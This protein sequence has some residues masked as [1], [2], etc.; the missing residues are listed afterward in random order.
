MAVSAVAGLASA[1]GAAA[2]GL[3]FFTFEAL[4]VGAFFGYFALG[5]GLSALSRALAPTPKLGSQMRG[6]TQT[7]REPAGS[8]KLV[9]GQLRVGGQ[10][11]FIANSGTDNEYLHLVIVFAAHEIESFEEFWFNDNKV[12][13]NNAVVS[14]WSDYV[15]IAKFDGSQTTAD[16]TLTSVSNQWTNNHILNGM[17]YAHVRLKWDADQ[18]PQGVPNI[19]A[20]IKGKKVYD[21]RDSNQSATDASTWTYSQ[22]PALCVRDYLV[23]TKYGLGEDRTLIDSTALTA[24]A[25]LCEESISLD[26]GGTQDRYRL[27]G[28]I[29]TANQIKDNIEQMLSAMGGTMSYS[30]GK[31]F[32]RGAEY[33]TPTVTFDE[34][35]CVADIQLQ[36]KQSRRGAYNGVKGI[37][38]SEEK[39]YKVLDYPA[40][41]SSTYATE[42]GDPIYLDMPLPFVTNNVQAQRIAKIALLKSR[43]Q[44]VISMVVN[45]KGLRVKVGDTINVSN[46]HLGYSNK[47]FEVI[48]YSLAIADGGTLAVSLTCIE[49]ASAIY[50]WTTSDQEDFLSGGTLPLYDGRTVDNV[51]SLQHSVV[52]LKGPDGKLITSVDLT[53][54]A[55]N[56]AF[57]EFYVVT[58]EKDSDGDVYE[59]QTRNPRVRLSELTIGSA[60]TFTVK[61]QNLIGVRS[62]GTTL[63]VASL[64]GDTTAPAV[65]TSPS[66]TGGIRQITVEWTEATDEDLALTLIYYNDTDN[67]STATRS[68]TRGEE[69]VYT[70]ADGETSPKTKYFWLS[71]IDYSGNESA[72]TS[73]FTGTSVRTKENDIADGEVTTGKIENGAVTE[74]KIE[75]GAVTAGKI[76]VGEL[77]AITADIGDITAGTLQANT[78]TPIPDANDSPSGSET[79]AFIDLDNGKFVF[80]DANKHLLYDG[81][82]LVVKGE[83]EADILDVIDATI[84]GQLTANAI[85]AGAVT[86][87]SLSAGVFAEFDDRYGTS[88]GFYVTDTDEFFDGNSTKYVTVGTVAHSTDDIYFECRLNHSWSWPRNDTGDKL[89]AN[90]SFEY[91]TDNST[92]TTVPSSTTQV[93]T[94]TGVVAQYATLYS[95]AE[96]ITY[97]MTGSALT[98]GNYYFRVKIVAQNSTNAFQLAAFGSGSGVP[99]AFEVQESSGLS[100]AGGNADTLDGLDSTQFLRSDT[101]DTFDGNLTI[102]GDLILQG[103]IDQYNVTNLTVDDKTI[104]VNAGSTQALSDGA[105]LIVDRGTAADAS[106]TWDETN[107]E[108]DFSHDVTAPNLS[109]SNWNTAYTYSQVG[110]LP[111]A[112]GTVTGAVT[113]QDNVT[114]DSADINEIYIGKGNQNADQN[115][116]NIGASSSYLLLQRDADIPIELWGSKVESRSTHYF[117]S[118]A[119]GKYINTAG[120]AVLGDVTTA[121]IDSVGTAN[122]GN[123]GSG[124]YKLNIHTTGNQD[125][126]AIYATSTSGTSDQS[127]IRFFNDGGLSAHIGLAVD[128]GRLLPNTAANDFAIK[129]FGSL[130]LGNGNGTNL[131]TFTNTGNMK[132]GNDTVLTSNKALTNIASIDMPTS[133]SQIMVNAYSTT[134]QE[135]G[136][137]FFRDGFDSSAKYNLSIMARSRADDGSTDGLSINGYEGIAFSTGSNS[138]NERLFIDSSGNFDFNDGAISNAGAITSEGA[139]TA[140]DGSTSLG[141]YVGANQVINGSRVATFAQVISS[142]TLSG[143]SLYFNNSHSKTKIRLLGSTD[144]AHN[145]GTESYNN[146]YGPNSW[147]G[148]TIGHRFYGTPTSLIARL[149]TGGASGDLNSEFYGS[150]KIDQTSSSLIDH[151]VLEND[152]AGGAGGAIAFKQLGGTKAKLKSY[153]GSNQWTFAIDTEDTTNAFEIY[154]DG[155]VNISGALESGGTTILSST[156]RF[157]ASNGTSVKA[158]YSFDGDSGTGISRTAAGRID[159]LSSGAIKAYIKTGTSNPISPTMYVDGRTEINGVVTWTGGSSTNANTAYGWGDHSTQGYLTSSSSIAATQLTGTINNNRLSSDVLITDGGTYSTGFAADLDTI[160]GF[161][162]HR[163]TGFTGTDHRAFTGHHNLIQIPNTS[164]SGPYEVQLAFTTVSSGTPEFKFRSSGVTW[165]DWV[166]VFNDG[167]HPNADKWTTA[168]T[169]SLTGAITGSVSWDGS[170]N[171]SLATTVGDLGSITVTDLTVDGTTNASVRID[172]ASTSHH[173]NLLYYTNGSLSWRIWQ[174][175]AD[176]TLAIRNE[177]STTN[178]ITMTN[179]DTLFAN[180]VTANGSF[181]TST[182]STAVG[183][184][185]GSTQILEGSTR[186]LKNIGTINSGSVTSSGHV[187]ATNFFIGTVTSDLINIHTD[188]SNGQIATYRNN[189]GYF[190]HRT[191]A[192][193]NNDGTTV[194]LQQRV[195]ND[196]NYSS[197]GNFT[198]HDFHLRTNNTNR[199]SIGSAGNVSISNALSIVNGIDSNTGGAGANLFRANT[200]DGRVLRLRDRTDNGGN[201]IQFEQNNGSGIW[202]V[203]GRSSQFYVYKNSGTGAGLKWNI[204]SSGNHTFNGDMA[205]VNQVTLGTNLST[206]N[207]GRLRVEGTF[208]NTGAASHPRITFNDDNF[209]IGA[210]GWATTGNN[211][212]LYLWSYNGAG[213]KIRFAV[214]TD[215]GTDVTNAAWTTN[216]TIDNDGNFDLARGALEVGGNTVI[217][218]TRRFYAS[219]GTVAKAAFSFDGESSTGMYKYGTNQIGFT[220]GGSLMAYV[221]NVSGSAA[222]IVQGQINASG[223]NSGNWNTAYGW[224]DH[225]TAGYLQ[226]NDNITVGTISSGAITTS[227]NFLM[228]GGYSIYLGTTSRFSSDNNGGFGINYG[229]TGGTATASLSIYNNTTATIQLNRNGTISSGAITSS[230]ALT[231][232]TGVIMNNG[233]DKYWVRW[234]SAST[235]GLYYRQTPAQKLQFLFGGSERWG[236]DASGNMNAYNNITAGGSFVT[237]TSS[238]AL[239][240]YAG[241]TQVFEGST[242]N[243]KNIGT[244]S[245]GAITSSGHIKT[246]GGDFKIGGDSVIT[247]NRDVYARRLF[248]SDYADFSGILYLRNTINVLNATDNGWNTFAARSNGRFNLTIGSLS[249][250]STGQFENI[251][252]GIAPSTPAI[253][254]YHTD[255]FEA[256]E[257]ITNAGGSLIRYRDNTSTSIEIG[258]QGGVPVIRTGSQARLTVDGSDLKINS[259]ALKIANTSVITSGRFLE[260]V[261]LEAGAAGARFKHS[262]WHQSTDGRNRFYFALNSHT[263]YRTGNAFIYR[264]N[265]DGGV[266]TIDAAGRMRLQTSSDQLSIG[267]GLQIGNNTFTGANGVFAS[268]RI[269]AMV[270]GSLTSYVYASTYN[271]ANFPDYGFVFIHGPSTSSY[272][273]WSISPDGPAKG[274]ALNFIYGNGATNIHT[275]APKVVFD[276]SGN[277]DIKAGAL[278][279]F[280][281]GYQLRLRRT[282]LVDQDWRFYSWSGGLNIFPAATSA[283]YFGRDGATTNVSIYNGNLVMGTGDTTI[284]S[285]ARNVE[286]INHFGVANTTTVN[287]KRATFTY[288]ASDSNFQLAIA[289]GSGSTSNSEQAWLGLYYGSNKRSGISFLRSGNAYGGDMVF[290]TSQNNTRMTIAGQTGNIGIGVTPNASYKLYVGGSIAQSS[291]SIYSYGDIVIGQGGLKRGSTD[292]ITSALELR[293]ITKATIGSPLSGTFPDTNAQLDI[294]STTAQTNFSSKALSYG[295]DRASIVVD[296]RHGSTKDGVLG[297]AGPMMDFRAHNASYQWSVAQIIGTVDPENGST[298]QGGLVFSTSGGGTA[299]PT[300]RRNQGAAPTARMLIGAGGNVTILTG[301]LKFGNSLTSVITSAREIRN[302]EN[303]NIGNLRVGYSSLGTTSTYDNSIESTGSYLLLQRNQSAP[304]EIWGSRAELRS[305]TYFGSLSDAHGYVDTSGNATFE[306]NV[307]AYGSPSDIRLKENVERIAD[308]IAKVKKL[309]GVTFNYKKDGGRSTGLIAQQLLEVLPEVVYETEDLATGEEHYAVRYG[310]VVGLLVEAMK[311]QQ[312]T[313]ESLTKRIEELENG[314]N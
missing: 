259:G 103:G 92:W 100:A 204:D 229:T 234:S 125:A 170:A 252:I 99:I 23:D 284:I 292:L 268:S 227:A 94:A 304:I 147:T 9:Y 290:T 188:S 280:K 171:A 192:D 4:T 82:T 80:G 277:V 53:W 288:G 127:A 46:T 244:I 164:S 212:D 68:K 297:Y 267:A 36:T 241:S 291:G 303:A 22:N 31:Y 71:S 196:G 178:V 172:R 191:Y 309:D 75:D 175:G 207:A 130:H 205:L 123:S 203:V 59:V 193:Y 235:T 62:S 208:A 121:D 183:I 302:V 219:N 141:Y 285:S 111:L 199:I 169:L 101:N 253:K 211:D 88:G 163:V 201:I 145:I 140:G 70:L 312:D 38:V 266:A 37:F 143:T 243:L 65:P 35:D 298:F 153:F 115:A 190:L 124:A 49:T 222:L 19:S 306:G 117:G 20:V 39:D 159:F 161:R 307:T 160:T 308:P 165:S 186:N 83:L 106:I 128:A 72:K 138:Y 51:T 272:N 25:N 237:A 278:Q 139:I 86:V 136:G 137:I 179:T 270:N 119:G 287:Q 257:F 41:I 142:G 238:S 148:G 129:T 282:D 149:G 152:N 32:L 3:A 181:V 57:V 245:S 93:A 173:N 210:G 6:L 239:G 194:E 126:I 34:A 276:G 85:S 223:G 299:N 195:G 52:G 61:A 247:S 122:F 296:A 250:N 134:S 58:Y 28:Q 84:T 274:N 11:V 27:N 242:R 40:Q 64:A 301:D 7:T 228:T 118:Q 144:G 263:Y 254:V 56:D 271:D 97:T 217:A 116:R 10:V 131:F 146:T 202:E 279:A 66:T 261:T 73:S 232:S 200:S 26:G 162:I 154:D 114:A 17:A 255:N 155:T 233:G 105:G 157:Y 313:I 246:T 300:G 8:R 281:A 1:I 77:S 177:A 69:F 283:V 158:A 18:Y 5:A 96:D 89:N 248:Y 180:N 44:T 91:S 151:L 135:G 224:G 209:G 185:A 29:D 102:T 258:I 60:Y 109:I 63:N 110:H 21:P 236:V 286:N 314:D 14:A 107:D 13:E 174:S 45:L 30:G 176:N 168:R 166:K 311:E 198:A 231:T 225:S 112:G 108:F 150:V 54:T 42:D 79:G 78:S 262:D 230:G 275:T 214:T 81:S 240:I 133:G 187:K 47:V 55:P 293:N 213:R 33:I 249:S 120:A 289:N 104:T 167:Y 295:S 76:T 90:V 16:S 12:Y 2:A 220:A 256:G 98:A 251:G 273:V 206:T 132:V 184:Y 15:T 50:D 87:E 156:R 216:A 221:Q 215:G 48:D 43:Q 74:V 182:A 189:A 67:L 265:A 310:N 226:T 294:A 260:N 24:A 269:G 264:N 95:I 113:V 197:I 218:T 305:A